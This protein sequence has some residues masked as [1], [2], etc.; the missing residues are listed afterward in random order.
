MSGSSG[1]R[2]LG[3]RIDAEC[4]TNRRRRTGWAT[5]PTQLRQS[6]ARIDLGIGERGTATRPSGIV[7][8]ASDTCGFVMNYV[9]RDV[10]VIDLT[11]VPE[12]PIRTR[13]FA[14]LRKVGA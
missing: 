3:S 1:A 13:L 14:E 9:S 7:V 11:T 12:Q 4:A 10:T 6:A 8:D 2:A 5:L